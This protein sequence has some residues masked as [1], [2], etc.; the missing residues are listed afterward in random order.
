MWS[1]R[2]W[3]CSKLESERCGSWSTWRDSQSAS[4]CW[5]LCVFFK[6]RQNKN[7]SMEADSFWIT[8]HIRRDINVSNQALYQERAQWA[9]LQM[10]DMAC[11]TCFLLSFPPEPIQAHGQPSAPFLIPPALPLYTLPRSTWTRI[12]TSSNIPVHRLLHPH[13]HPHGEPYALVFISIGTPSLPNN[14]VSDFP[15]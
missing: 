11:A 14:V 8:P 4:S 1:R 7:S 6:G 5:P 9:S 10:L 15:G 12:P 3:W 13:P 2:M